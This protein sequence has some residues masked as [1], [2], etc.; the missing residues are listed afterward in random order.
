VFVA[1]IGALDRFDPVRGGLPDDV[2]APTSMRDPTPP[3]DR[4]RDCGG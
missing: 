4:P 3:P 1:A 2:P